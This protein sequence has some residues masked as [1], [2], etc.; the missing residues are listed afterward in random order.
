[1][2]HFKR[3]IPAHVGLSALLM[4]GL[5]AAPAAAQEVEPIS[6]G[7]EISQGGAMRDLRIEG[8]KLLLTLVEARDFALQRNLAL[9]VERYRQEESEL[10]LWQSEGIYDPSLSANV[11]GFDETSPSASN[12]D[13]ADIQTTEG[14]N[15][16]FGL[17]RLFSSGGTGRVDFN[18]RRQETNSR[19]AALNPSF[20]SDFDLSFQQ[21]LLRDRGEDATNRFIRIAR[22]NLDISRENFESQVVA[23]LQSVADAYWNLVEAQAQLG[24]AEESLSLAKQL[25]EQNRIR[26]DVGTLAP[27]ELVQS[28][29]GIATREEQIIR[30]RALVGDSEDVLRQLMNLEEPSLWD[31]DLILET[32]AERDE[33]AIDVDEA[34]ATAL[35]ERPELRTKRLAQGDLDADI[36]YFRNQKLP[37]VDLSVVYGLNG[38]GGDLTL[39]DFVTGEILQQSAGGYSDALDQIT[40]ADFEGWSA[41]VNVVYPIFNRTGKAAVALAEAG[42]ERGQVELAD[43]ELAVTTEVRRIARFVDTRHQTRESA[44]VSRRL[45][46]KNLE[47]EQKRYQNGM[48]TSFQVLQIQEDLTEARSREVAAVTGYR[49]ALVQYYR[50]IGRLTEVSGV[51][52]VGPES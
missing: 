7:T 51:E 34:I 35:A 29:A 50:A 15:W 44:R 41:S 43:L 31:L 3:L 24:V 37:R 47:A 45:E 30:A 52:I 46:E 38:L 42:F 4:L 17:S 39:R 9:V 12:L 23:I 21:P 8:G 32:D 33:V 6:V 49:K 11:G 36:E 13:G 16:N 28:E 26:V 27:L 1:M 22:T 40:G 14:Q 48:S 5:I 2:Y 20:R 18:S 25:H 19:F 10:S